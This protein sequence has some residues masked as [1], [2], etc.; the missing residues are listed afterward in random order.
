MKGIKAKM[1][2]YS[3]LFTDAHINGLNLEKTLDHL[4]YNASVK[5]AEYKRL[6]GVDKIAEHIKT[7]FAS[8]KADPFI[9]SSY[10]EVYQRIS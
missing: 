3:Y 7:N 1:V 5:P 10:E 4:H 8:Y 9:A 2:A 6:G